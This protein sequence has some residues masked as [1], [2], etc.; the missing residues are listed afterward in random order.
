MSPPPPP[1]LDLEEAGEVAPLLDLERRIAELER[2]LATRDELIGVV[3]HELRNPL[4]P[5]FLQAYHLMAELR[6]TKTGTVSTEWLVPRFELFVRGLDRLLE[7]L[8][9]LMDVA[10]LQS[11]SGIALTDEELDLSRIADDVV[12][13]MARE[14]DTAGC[15][16]EISTMGPVIGRWDRLRLEQIVGNLLSN[17]IH[18]A[19]GSHI[20]IVVRA[21]SADAATLLVRDD[22]PGIALELQ[23]RIF[24]RFERGD[25]QHKR[26][27]L[28]LGLW[29]VR[30]LCERMGGRVAVDSQPGR[31]ASFLVTLPRARRADT[32]P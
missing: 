4:S 27:G 25:T 2:A 10:A 24:D 21:R 17:A 19:A 29:I 11:P 1:V 31:G 13:T 15:S 23:P 30:R 28:G 3:G 22:G 32:N 7:R 5:V 26:G 9:R 18:F 8:N 6:K 14:A 16:I 20:E 12:L